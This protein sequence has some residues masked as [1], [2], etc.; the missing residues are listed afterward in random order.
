MIASDGDLI[1]AVAGGSGGGSKGVL[2]GNVLCVLSQGLQALGSTAETL[3]ASDVE[4]P[5]GTAQEHMASLR[6]CLLK[7]FKWVHSIYPFID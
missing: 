7:H 2:L 3:L 5:D 1:E 6:A 4:G